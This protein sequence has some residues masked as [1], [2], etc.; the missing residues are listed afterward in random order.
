VD[1]AKKSLFYPRE[2][3]LANPTT[4]L[5]FLAT[6]FLEE[7][8]WHQPP[9]PH[10]ERMNIDVK[11]HGETHVGK[12]RQENEDQFLI[13]DLTKSMKVQQTSLGL[14]HQT[15]LLGDTQGKLLL[16]ADGVGGHA[17]GERASSLAVDGVANYILNAMDWF[18]RLNDRNEDQLKKE[19]KSAFA[20]SQTILNDEAED[21][22]QRRGMATTLTM[23]YIV[24]PNM[25]VVH[26]GDTRCYIVHDR[27]IEQVT[28]DHTIG[29]LLR[30][31][32][33]DADPNDT[34][35][36]HPMSHA[37]W[38]VIGGRDNSLEPQFEKVVLSNNDRLLLCSDGLT[39]YLEDHELAYELASEATPQ[40][41]CKT[42][43]DTSN[44]RGGKDNITCVVAKFLPVVGD[45]PSKL[46]PRET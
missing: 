24:W 10:E 18:M 14:N 8:L 13:A 7:A 16:V 45:A 6:R 41:I 23:A 9:I 42:F 32:E 35:P 36:F 46:V 28:T 40:Q 43:I 15:R 26:V 12:H 2:G 44:S 37:L 3:I 1:F 11:C 29:N 30:A 4:L 34:K 20:H 39:R 5:S 17:S 27:D 19:L 38:N 25:Y 33:K 21:I 22:P 31:A